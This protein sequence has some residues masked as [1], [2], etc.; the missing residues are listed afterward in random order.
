MI[1]AGGGAGGANNQPIS[2]GGAGGGG[3][4]GGRLCLR[5]ISVVPSNTYT[6]TVGAGGVA[7]NLATGTN[8]GNSVFGSYT[9]IGGGGGGLAKYLF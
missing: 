4:A 2:K 8:G 7:M 9:A 5:N 1:V 6:V 3:G